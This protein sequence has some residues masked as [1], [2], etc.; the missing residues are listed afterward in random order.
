M[1]RFIFINSEGKG[2]TILPPSVKVYFIEFL[3]AG[4]YG[5][6]L[7]AIAA[8]ASKN[9]ERI[10]V[11][12]NTVLTLFSISE[13]ERFRTEFKEWVQQVRSSDPD[14]IAPYYPTEKKIPNYFN[15]VTN[16]IKWVADYINDSMMRVY[17]LD[18]FEFYG[19]FH[20]AIVWEMNR[21]ESGR[22][23]L[24]NAHNRTQ[25]K[26]DWKRLSGLA[27]GG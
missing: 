16:D 14:L 4:S 9:E 1:K 20:D 25:T 17:Q 10:P 12:I 24:K 26:P 18:I 8:I 11:D 13:I 22:E 21:T 23:Y 3:G 27:N 15:C 7:N 6:L 5:E 19:L 2:L